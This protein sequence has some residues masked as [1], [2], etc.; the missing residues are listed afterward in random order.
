MGTLTTA[1]ATHIFQE[2]WGNVSPAVPS[3]GWSF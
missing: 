3:G 1:D 2:F